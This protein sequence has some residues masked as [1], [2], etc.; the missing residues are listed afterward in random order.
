MSPLQHLITAGVWLSVATH[1]TTAA[2]FDHEKDPAYWN[3]KAKETINSAL[4]LAPLTHKAKN[5]ILFLG[6][7][8]GIAT[9]SAARIYKGQLDGRPGEDSQM[10]METFPYVAL[11]KTY[12][13][14]QQVPD[15]AGTATAYLCGV[16]TNA[17]ILGLSA[18]AVYKKCNTTS[19]NEVESILHRAKKAGK[20][21]GI[22]TTTRVQH[23]SPAAAYA[24]VVSRSWYSDA[25]MPKDAVNQSCTDIAYQLVHNTDIDV[26]LGGG[27]RYMTPKGTMD[28]EHS[29]DLKQNGTRKDGANLIKTW[30]KGRKDALYVWDKAGF[31]AVNLS[32]TNYLMG[33][34]EP[35][36]MPYELHRDP[37]KDPSIVDMTEKAIRILSK[38]PN[39]FFLFVEGGRIDHGHH[40]SKAKMALMETV[41]LD[42]A[43]QRAGELTKESET[44]T[45]VTAD[46]SHVFTFGGSPR[47]GNSILGLSQDKADDK[48]PYTSL[49]YGNG[50]GFAIL[51]GTRA[52]ITTTDTG[53]NDYMQQSAVNM[54]SETHGGEDVA[55]MAKGPL[56]HLFHG[57]HEQNYIAHV[58]A[59][60]MCIEPY[61][62]CPPEPNME[63]R[64]HATS[65]LPC[66]LVT[67]LLLLI[68]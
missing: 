15:S 38:N 6:D 23:A 58:I 65:I 53:S 28:P 62:D 61:S 42:K 59:Y 46:H 32:T 19:G 54:S 63:A 27:R 67:L 47:R 21:V 52:N 13:V 12:N 45:V 4:K 8:M 56:A 55:I 66:S 10:A 50:P 25:D 20:S 9:I 11:S 34:F 43:I 16:K 48:M 31:E 29:H 18:A 26:I 41:M 39:G 24:H 1:S 22:V 51:N 40:G 7:G 17:G 68:R 37:A 35:K 30:L 5:A 14:D 44:L 2:G 49:L 57:V 36:D 33:L 60:A 64:S 3:G